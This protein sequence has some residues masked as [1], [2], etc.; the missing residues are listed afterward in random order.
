MNVIITLTTAGIDTGPFDLY[1]NVDSYVT[2]FANNVD[3]SALVAGYN[4][5]AVP[6]GTT[7]IRVKS[8][9]TCTN[10][11][12]LAVQGIPITTTT[13]TTTLT[14]QCSYNGFTIICD[15]PAT[16]TTTTT[17]S[18]NAVSLRINS[19]QLAVCTSIPQTY[20]TLG[21]A[22]GE[23]TEIFTDAGLTMPY[24]SGGNYVVASTSI[25]NL[26]GNLVGTFSGVNCA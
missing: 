18:V 14:A 13:T 6:N 8:D 16:T 5:S 25:F 3:K 15:V 7:T 10:F 1:S 26:S 24:S 21:G 2:P 4:S 19:D 23:G 20:Y 12:D 17:P 22:L 11:V 9:G